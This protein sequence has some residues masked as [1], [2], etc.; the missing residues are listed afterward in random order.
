[1]AGR[2]KIGTRL[3]FREQSKSKGYRILLRLSQRVHL[4]LSRTSEFFVSSL[5]PLS[6]VDSS[7]K[8]LSI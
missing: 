7:P 4:T 3:P 8:T 2:R 6:T 1:M 5:R